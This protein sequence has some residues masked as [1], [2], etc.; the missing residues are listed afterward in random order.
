M[1][2][3]A[4]RGVRGPAMT[5]FSRHY[6][7]GGALASAFE[8]LVVDAFRWK[9]ISATSGCFSIGDDVFLLESRHALSRGDEGAGA[10]SA[11][12]LILTDRVEG[13]LESMASIFCHGACHSVALLR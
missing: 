3:D 13:N 1:S 10:S 6:D 9:N 12:V 4:R 7:R 11:S 5:F 8:K 2:K